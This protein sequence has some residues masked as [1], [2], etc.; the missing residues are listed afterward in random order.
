MSQKDYLKERIGVV[1][2]LLGVL[3]GST[4]WIATSGLI[5]L[6]VGASVIFIIGYMG[7]VSYLFLDTIGIVLQRASLPAR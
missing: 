2:W 6:A 5:P 3:L 4:A 7:T 1:K